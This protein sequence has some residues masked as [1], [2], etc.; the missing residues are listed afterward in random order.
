MFLLA[1]PGQA[2]MVIGGAAAVVAC[3]LQDSATS[4]CS[5]KLVQLLELEM[6]PQQVQYV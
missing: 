4:Q 3:D 2:L 5:I 1:N 6:V